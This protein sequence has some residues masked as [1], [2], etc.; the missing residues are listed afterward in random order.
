M[1]WLTCKFA[2]EC[3][4]RDQIVFLEDEL[5]S[6][7]PEVLVSNDKLLCLGLLQSARSLLPVGQGL[8]FH[9]VHLTIQEFLAALHLVTLPN[10]EKL[11][12]C[13]AHAESD[14]FS[15]VW[16]FVFGLECQKKGSYSRKVVSLGDEVVDRFLKVVDNSISTINDRAA[17][18]LRL[19]LCHCSMESSCN[20]VCLKLAKQINGLFIG[21]EHKDSMGDTPHDCM[22]IFQVLR[23]TFHC[24]HL[25]IMLN[26][27][28]LNNELLKELAD[29]LCNARGELQ[30]GDLSFRSNMLSDKGVVD[31]FNRASASFSSL[32]S[33]SLN[34][35]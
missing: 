25:V 26:N 31:L 32:Q 14:R 11:K 24:P 21:Y 13:E 5:V 3:L 28:G 30:A 27:C 35:G 22:A 16:R 23:Y 4:S 15:M 9:F 12:V 2:F 29:I 19:M 33:L 17:H 8:S 6:F 10:E 34:G 20:S 1:F 7:F 18:R